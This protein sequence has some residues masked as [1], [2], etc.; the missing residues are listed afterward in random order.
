MFD[1]LRLANSEGE[2]TADLAPIDPS[3]FGDV[4]FA[5]SLRRA[6]E[7]AESARDQDRARSMARHPSIQA[8]AQA[9]A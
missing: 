3:T 2:A 9:V 5:T 7:I 8:R 1:S 6:S 4:R